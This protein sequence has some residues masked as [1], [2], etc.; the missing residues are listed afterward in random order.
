MVD[1]A[2]K[3]QLRIPLMEKG[4]KDFPEYFTVKAP[5]FSSSK[6]KG[7]D[8][9]LGPEM[10]STGEVLGIGYHFHE[11]LYKALFPKGNPFK[12]ISNTS[13]VR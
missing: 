5:V 10:K 6:L 13:S 8:H 2:V 3:A 11:A 1:L 4:L 7:V 9:I 12:E